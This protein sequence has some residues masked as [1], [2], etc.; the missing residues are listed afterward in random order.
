MCL[1][2]WNKQNIKND[3]LYVLYSTQFMDDDG[4]VAVIV[5]IN[6]LCLKIKLMVDV[7][8][9]WNLCL[10]EQPITQHFIKFRSII[11]VN[12]LWRHLNIGIA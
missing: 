9:R 3:E 8:G 6:G 11:Y 12:G 2:G 5:R 4:I 7:Y 10:E 1:F